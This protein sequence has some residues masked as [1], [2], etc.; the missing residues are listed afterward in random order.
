MQKDVWGAL[1]SSG[2]GYPSWSLTSHASAS[3]HRLK[4]PTGCQ[5]CLPAGLVLAMK[6]SALTADL[7]DHRLSEP[8]A[9]AELS[10]RLSQHLHKAGPTVATQTF[11][12]EQVHAFYVKENQKTLVPALRGKERVFLTEWREG[13]GLEEAPK[14][15]NLGFSWAVAAMEHPS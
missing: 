11:V 13:E 5:G 2:R 7:R 12:N 3:A 14:G 1:L 8:R 15:E 10:P 9:C 4:T 6:F